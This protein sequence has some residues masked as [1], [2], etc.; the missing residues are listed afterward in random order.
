MNR[1]TGK[2]NQNNFS[3]WHHKKLEGTGSN[4]RENNEH[5]PHDTV[6]PIQTA[7]WLREKYDGRI[8]AGYTQGKKNEHDQF[9]DVSTY[10]KR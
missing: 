6:L 1:C 9:L 3:K 2:K 5:F 7:A 4:P 10:I 8:P